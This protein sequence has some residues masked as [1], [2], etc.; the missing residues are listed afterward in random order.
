MSARFDSLTQAECAAM[1]GVDVRTIR[2]WDEDG[3]PRHEAGTYSAR[4]S[5]NWRIK[6]EL[7]TELDLEEQR[8]RLA[9][10]QA[11]KAAMENA[12]RRGELLLASKLEGDLE[13]TFTTF[14]QRM[15]GAASKLAPAANPDRPML[16]QSVIEAEHYAILTELADDLGKIGRPDDA[17]AKARRRRG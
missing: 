4:E 8:A 12:L 17:L 1:H 3:H 15:L 14:R 7:G 9:S 11:D 16:A 6:R 13:R 5:I 2:R 10:E